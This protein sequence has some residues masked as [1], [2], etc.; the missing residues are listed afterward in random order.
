MGNSPSFERVTSMGVEAS[1]PTDTTSATIR[2]RH[3]KDALVDIPF[4]DEPDV[5]T[6]QRLWTRAA[7]KFAGND[8]LG[9]RSF[10]AD[11]SRGAYEFETYAQVNEAVL[12]VA[13]GLKHLGTKEDQGIGIFGINSPEWI[14]SFMATLYIGGICVP[15]YDTL[16]PDAVSYILNDAEVRTAFVSGDRF[17]KL[18]ENGGDAAEAF[19]NIICFDEVS[20][21]QRKKAEDA[22]LTVF[23]LDEL[24]ALS[25]EQVQPADRQPTDLIYY[26]YT[27]GTT[28]NPKGVMLTNRNMLSNVAGLKCIG[29]ELYE[30]DVYLSYLPLA[31]C[32]EA[33]MQFLGMAYG[34]SVGFYQGNVKLLTDDIATLR[35]TVFAGVPRVYSRIYDKVQQTVEASSWLK[36]SIFE[37][38]FKGQLENVNMGTRNSMWDSLVFN[39]IKQRLGGR[40]RMMATGAAPMPAHIMDFLK[41]AFQCEVFQGYGMTENAAAA[42]ITPLGYIENAGKVGEPIPNCEIRLAD[43]PEMEYLHTDK[44]YPRGEVCIRGNNVMVGYKNLPDKTKEDLDEDGWLHTGDI[45]Q[46]LA[47]GALQIIDRKKN[48]F[49]LAQG[50]YV[51][52]EEL[53]G[54][55]KKIKWVGQIWIYGDSF[56]TT[57][58]AVIVP[59]PETIMPWC[60]EHGIEGDYAT[61]V[62]DPKV[63]E[64]FT[65]E[66]SKMAKAERVAGFK[67]PRDVI[68]EHRINDLGQGFS[69]DN[70]CLTPTFKLRRPQLL[71]RYRDKID[72][73]YEKRDGKPVKK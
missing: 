5:N 19:K 61:A 62:Q 8:C 34:G 70:D 65:S 69:T 27:S 40:I 4:E 13:A 36:K 15:L 50:E 52:A 37:T 6:I 57:L 9:I 56:H 71:K 12:K 58:V 47:D 43:V 73:I 29:V 16:G 25:Q 2:H 63:E 23:T 35:P 45:G 44:P 39:K 72:P 68:V 41:V 38:A 32:F 53:E 54:I 7:T 49:K 26:M 20:P 14:K 24:M 59:D 60:K 17:E 51:A 48:I 21:E 10:E 46:L 31:H 28:G 11:G 1:P 42:V 64:M 30:T 33:L 18:V 55:F 66:I 67:V 22:G 3:H